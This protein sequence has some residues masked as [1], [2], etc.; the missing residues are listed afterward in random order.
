MSSNGF[1]PTPSACSAP[2]VVIGG[3]LAGLAS[4][5]ELSDR[6]HQVLLLEA[7]RRLGGRAASFR[8]PVTG[9][10]IDN[11]QHAMMGAYHHT[12]SFLQRIG[13]Q[14]KLTR[15]E[16]LRVPYVHVPSRQHATLEAAELPAPLHAA[17]AI[18]RFA[19]LPP[20]ERLQALLGGLKILTICKQNP[21]FLQD[22]TVEDLLQFCGQTR[23]TRE[24]LWH[25]VAVATMNERPSRA[26]AAPFAEVVVR[27]FFASRRDSQFVFPRVP[28]SVLYVHDA[29]KFIQ[30]RG[31]EVRTGAVVEELV[32]ERGRALAVRLRNGALL[33]ASAVVCALPPEGAHKL[34]APHGI[35]VPCGAYTPI[36]SLHLWFDG[37]PRL[38]SFV[39]LLGTRAQWVFDRESLW[40]QTANAA[41]RL[42]HILSVV[43]SAAYEEVEFSDGT[44]VD[45]IKDE[46][47]RAFPHL[48]ALRLRHAAVIRE[49][50][51]TPSLTPE[52]E[53]CRP[54]IATHLPNVF[55]AG[56]WV[57]TRLPATI[58]SAVASGFAAAEAVVQAVGR[59]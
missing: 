13:A 40:Q 9:D 5:V 33:P 53:R 2:V 19:L 3:G 35:D 12:L 54:T 46:L 45:T 29:L 27:A 38:P 47:A 49:R 8:E 17:F 39:G 6:G 50:R 4:A 14:P 52:F 23:R 24:R 42:P 32:C 30:R 1:S 21:R 22:L 44:L 51:A 25:P 36:V 16:R 55:L 56:D 10:E 37:P 28:L 15:Q 34:L 18:A 48:R 57:A 58:E 11:G 43:I 31:G 26:A 20:R 7:K 41:V 59:A